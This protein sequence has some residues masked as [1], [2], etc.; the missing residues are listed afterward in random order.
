MLE[1]M[2]N[3][4]TDENADIVITDYFIN[5]K[6]FNSDKEEILCIQKPSST[7]SQQILIDILENKIFGALWNTFLL[8]NR[9][10]CTQQTR[11]CS[12]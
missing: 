11:S 3:K 1:D 12:V 2:Y 9:K 5:K 6:A 7:N 8:P 10:P 4:A